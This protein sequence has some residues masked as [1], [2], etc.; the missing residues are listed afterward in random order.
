MPIDPNAALSLPQDSELRSIDA[1][2][3]VVEASAQLVDDNELTFTRQHRMRE[4][5]RTWILL[6]EPASD[7]DYRLQNF[8][9]RTHRG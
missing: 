4:T 2:L 3:D 7:G 6:N 5:W 8:G 1:H 9:F